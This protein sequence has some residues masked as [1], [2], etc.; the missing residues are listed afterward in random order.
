MLK[1]TSRSGSTRM[2]RRS[3]SNKSKNYA[4]LK[5]KRNAEHKKQKDLML[6]IK[7]NK[8]AKIER[9]K[10]LQI[11]KM[12]EWIQKERQLKLNKN[13]NAREQ[14]F[15]KLLKDPNRQNALITRHAYPRRLNLHKINEGNEHNNN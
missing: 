3:S 12:N 11:N 10:Q 1:S 4:T 5:L 15:I 13:T 9:D 2:A 7:I 6:Q 8:A 14:H